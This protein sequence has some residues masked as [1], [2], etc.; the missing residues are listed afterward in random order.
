M[1]IHAHPLVMTRV[2]AHH[3]AESRARVDRERLATLAAGASGIDRPQRR[4]DL[5]SAT[6]DAIAEVLA[7]MLV[8]GATAAPEPPG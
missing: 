3:R 2:A 1:T 6:A 8:A 7:L 4:S 5:L